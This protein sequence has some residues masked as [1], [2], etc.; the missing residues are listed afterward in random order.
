MWFFLLFL[1]KY[2]KV[3]VTI[4]YF[5]HMSSIDTSTNHHGVSQTGNKT[6]LVVSLVL[7][8]LVLFAFGYFKYAEGTMQKSMI[9]AQSTV[10]DLNAKISTLSKDH[11]IVAYQT[12]EGLKTG[13]Q[14]TFAN[15]QVQSF[16]TE[17]QNIARNY[18]LR[19]TGFAYQNGVVTTSAEADSFSGDSIGD[20]SLFIHDFRSGSGSTFFS[21][22]PVQ[23]VGG[24]PGMRTFPVTFNVKSQSV[25]VAS[26][27]SASGTGVW[28]STDK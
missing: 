14:N 18:R 4:S 21:L 1:K 20:V 17:Y 22:G 12:Y 28:V 8:A 27:V 3:P 26:P 5:S 10:T 11:T 2:G 23:T 19:F 9:D 15:A 13:L 25:T 24:V 16:I 6:M 7:L